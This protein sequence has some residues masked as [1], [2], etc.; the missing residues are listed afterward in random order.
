MRFGQADSKAEQDRKKKRK[1][2]RSRYT[3]K[4]TERHEQDTR[5]GEH[6]TIL[7]APHTFRSNLSGKRCFWN[8]IWR[9]CTKQF[10]VY[11]F[12]F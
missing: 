1:S 5:R 4:K 11:L 3:E 2:K 8:A 6:R 9:I 10:I 12:G 7:R